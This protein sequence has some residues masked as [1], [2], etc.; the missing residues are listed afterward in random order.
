LQN[1][2]RCRQNRQNPPTGGEWLANVGETLGIFFEAIARGD[3]R[4]VPAGTCWV[5]GRSFAWLSC[6]R[7]R[8]TILER[9]KDHLIS[10]LTRRLKRL[11]TGD[12]SA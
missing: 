1:S 5:V 7:Q 10:I 8:N 4:F 2:L 3:G 9:S 6:Y 11:V 12:L